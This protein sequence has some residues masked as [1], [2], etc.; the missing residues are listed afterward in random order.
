MVW[1]VDA[2]K[3][4][5]AYQ[6]Q[7]EFNDGLKGVVDLKT[8]LENDHREIIRELLDMELFNA[9]V[10]ANDTVCWKNGVDFAPEF[11]RELVLKYKRVA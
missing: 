10:V 8:A 1:I 11:L 4:E 6:I 7:L 3:A 5:G 9:F 2:K